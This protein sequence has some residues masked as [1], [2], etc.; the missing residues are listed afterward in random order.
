M[1]IEERIE[2]SI[3][4]VE[5]RREK[6]VPCRA[7]TWRRCMNHTQLWHRKKGCHQ[8]STS[9]IID[10][11]KP[12]PTF[13]LL[14]TVQVVKIS[15]QLERSQLRAIIVNNPPP[16]QFIWKPICR[17]TNNPASHASSTGR[18]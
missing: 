3:E 9:G 18:K 15:T 14:G 6:Q 11:I 5:G 8:C 17:Y 13:Q 16:N 7:D 10:E 4:D 1:S 12:D 2:T